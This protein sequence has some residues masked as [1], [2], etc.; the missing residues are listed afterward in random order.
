[1]D[2]ETSFIESV[3]LR[4]T[5]KDGKRVERL[6]YV[7][8]DRD[9]VKDPS[10]PVGMLYELTEGVEK[11]MERS[12][13]NKLGMLDV[14]KLYVY[15]TPKDPDV[16]ESVDLYVDREHPDKLASLLEALKK[17]VEDGEIGAGDMFLR[18]YKN[19]KDYGREDMWAEVMLCDVNGLGMDFYITEATPNTLAWVQ[20]EL[21]EYLDKIGQN[22]PVTDEDII[23]GVQ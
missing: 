17:D 9:L 13:L 8:V 4:Y 15:Y 14:A 1:M 2:Y 23:A 5:L 22:K 20:A 18:L 12:G 6:Y 16:Y 19:D 10:T 11:R 3:R 7:R 21:A